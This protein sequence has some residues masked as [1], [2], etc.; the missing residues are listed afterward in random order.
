MMALKNERKYISGNVV[1]NPET[2]KTPKTPKR[3]LEEL[4]KL[5][6]SKNQYRRQKIRTNNKVR[7]NT[8]L[9]LFLL[10]IICF[11]T[12]YRSSNIYTLQNEYLNLQNETRI[13]K[14]QNEDMKSKLINASSLNEMVNESE[15]LNLVQLDNDEYLK[16]DLNKNNFKD[17]EEIA[18][19]NNLIEKAMSFLS[20]KAF[21]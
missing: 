11:F 8:I 15:K 12:I 17:I 20:F 4:Q 13:L 10:A 2:K 5:Q 6:E 18:E 16:L 14:N 9:T 1:V 3:N 21:R 19:T 7:V